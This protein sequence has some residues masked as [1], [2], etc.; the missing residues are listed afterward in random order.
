MS[1]K[2]S[3]GVNWYDYKS[4]RFEINGGD[5]ENT[6]ALKKCS[7]DVARVKISRGDDLKFDLKDVNSESLFLEIDGGQVDNGFW[8]LSKYPGDFLSITLGD[9]NLS[10]AL[11]K[12]A[13]A[14][15]GDFLSITIPHHAL[16]LEEASF[17]ANA[18]VGAME[19]PYMT[20]K[21]GARDMLLSNEHSKDWSPNIK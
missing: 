1:M 4:R 20:F 7:F 19:L 21:K 17:L 16:S 3:A 9:S 18:E 10:M 5:F 13:S 2:H 8:K 6:N 12:E 11:I 14:W 15:K